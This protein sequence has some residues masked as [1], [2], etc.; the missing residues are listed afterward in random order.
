MRVPDPEHWTDDDS[1]GSF[2]G[3][4]VRN[5]SLEPLQDTLNKVVTFITSLVKCDSC[6]V[7][8]RE[9]D[10]LVLR[11][12]MNPHT[13]IVGRL[14][15]KF[16]EGITGWVAEHQEPVA[17]AVNAS[18]DPRFKVFNDLPEDRFESF[19][20][21]PVVT[22]GRVV[23]VINMQDRKPHLYTKRE[24]GLIA[25]VGALVGA[26]IEMARLE[27]ES[28][29]DLSAR[30]KAEDRFHKAFNANPEPISISTISEGRFIDVNESFLRATGYQREDV[31][32]NTFL[33]L[34]YWRHPSDR[35][36]MI[37]ALT[38]EGHVRDMEIPFLTK[39]GEQ[40]IA[41]HSAEVIE[42]GGQDC[43]LAIMK[44][45]T[46]SK[47]LEKRVRQSQKMEVVGRM[48]GGIAHDFDNLLGV[49][50][51]YGEILLDQLAGNA[52][53]HGHAEKIMSAA[54]RGALL[55]RQLLAFSRQQ[56]VETRVLNL[57]T[58]VEE[59]VKM[60]PRLIGEH[61]ELRTALEPGLG[62]VKA[63][64]G[65]IDQVIINLV[66]NARDAMPDGGKLILETRNVTLGLD[67]TSRNLPMVPGDYTMLVVSDT[68]V[69]M[70]AQTQ[71]HIFEPFFTTKEHGKGTGLGLATVYGAV[72]QNGGFV[73]VDSELGKG[74][75]FKIYLPRFSGD[76]PQRQEGVLASASVVR[77]SETI[78]LVEDDETLRTLS[79]SIL[80]ENGYVVLEAKDGPDAINRAR[81]H[82]GTIH[83]L[84]TDVIMPGMNGRIL[85]DKLTAL[86]PGI[87][88]V[89]MSGYTGYHEYE[90]VESHASVIAKPFT[91]EMLVRRVRDALTADV[92]CAEIA[93]RG[94]RIRR[95]ACVCRSVPSFSDDLQQ[96]P[97]YPGRRYRRASHGPRHREA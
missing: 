5:T 50:I 84:L 39:S 85:A 41:L 25:T 64:Q 67:Y 49:I 16:G 92:S 69:G 19:L 46:E 36:R 57:N 33:D 89:F 7:Y 55:I 30:K 95:Q 29:E 93:P 81:N 68:G 34:K 72:K 14:K 13:E 54:N 75:T 71:A 77:G 42:L 65:Q 8:V 10:D 9:G 27:G 12:S 74:T 17:V 21:V 52:R 79:R 28:A 91:R 51:G 15:L 59:L 86:F 80:Q 60:L 2:L 61:I 38:Y 44:D 66:V 23:A 35:S 6:F 31:I 62:L 53:L 96:F 1:A 63:D 4:L 58:A 24:I 87:R 26:E 56:V 76:A 37:G 82:R 47:E 32:G 22:R 97:R 90:L 70:D 20:S 83:L 88:V 78:L 45:I 40:R 94:V 48:S 43:V 11:A 18:E 3:D 73:W